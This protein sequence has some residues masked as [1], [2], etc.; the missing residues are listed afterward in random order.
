MKCLSLVNLA[1]NIAE[2][3]I[4][5]SFE[6]ISQ[7]PSKPLCVLHTRNKV[8]KISVLTLDHTISFKMTFFG[9]LILLKVKVKLPP[10]LS[11][12]V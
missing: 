8:F 11:T 6:N 9:L 4:H 2:Y 7:A 3:H 10:C 5:H 1:L 12:T